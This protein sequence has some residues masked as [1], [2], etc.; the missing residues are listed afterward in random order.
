MS[1]TNPNPHDTPHAEYIPDVSPEVRALLIGRARVLWEL[2][3]NAADSEGMT[4]SAIEE[5]ITGFFEKIFQS[6]VAFG[7]DLARM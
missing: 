5:K 3:G 1:G 7:R 2:I 4:D 6:G